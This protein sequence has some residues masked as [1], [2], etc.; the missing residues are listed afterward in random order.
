MPPSVVD[1]RFAAEHRRRQRDATLRVEILAL[2]LEHRMRREAD[3]QIQIARLGARRAVLAFAGD[4]HA[5]AVADAGGNP[6]VDGARVAV[7]L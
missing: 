6:D 5:R 4:A 2:A 3:A 1:L 7:V